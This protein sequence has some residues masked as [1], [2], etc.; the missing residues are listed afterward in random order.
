MVAD[1]PTNNI[2]LKVFH[3]RIQNDHEAIRQEEM[4]YEDIPSA[5]TVSRN[6]ILINYQRI[7]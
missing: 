3:C 6:E 1:D 4:T 2:D 5:R 7:N